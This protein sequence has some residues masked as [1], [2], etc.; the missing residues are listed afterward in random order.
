MTVNVIP[1]EQR[2]TRKEQT[3][4]LAVEGPWLRV[5]R[6]PARGASS[7]LERPCGPQSARERQKPDNLVPFISLPP[8]P[9][10][11]FRLQGRLRAAWSPQGVRTR[12]AICCVAFAGALLCAPR[13]R[14]RKSH[15][16]TSSPTPNRPQGSPRAPLS[17]ILPPELPGSCPHAPPGLAQE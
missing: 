10:A 17:P 7:T 6:R 1:D 14:P 11:P 16:L 8:P 13:E 2:G 15:R 9:P 4:G 5:S 12:A 3:S